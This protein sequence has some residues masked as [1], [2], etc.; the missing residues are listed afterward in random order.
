[1]NFQIK[2]NKTQG[3]LNAPQYS[4]LL[5]SAGSEEQKRR[6]SYKALTAL[7][8]GA[9]VVMVLDSSLLNVPQAEREAYALK[10]LE[11][12]RAFGLEYRY[13]KIA[14]SAGPSLFS[15]I[16][17]SK[18]GHAHEILAY[19]PQS[20]WKTDEFEKVLPIYGAWYYVTENNTDANAVMDD[21]KRM[22]DPEKL[23]YFKLVV[24]DSSTYGSMG[25][26]SSTLSLAEIKAMLE[27]E[28]G[29]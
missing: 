18:S 14:S 6:T 7:I 15:I 4:V 5:Q 16:F 10:F 12:I 20:V 11:D 13:G 22:T 26:N 21:L 19:V 1:M 27:R 25:V 9:D 2:E 8:G 28:I 24:F 3:E 29:H 23:D 17:G